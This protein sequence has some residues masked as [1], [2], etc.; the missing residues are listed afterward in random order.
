[1]TPFQSELI[2][3]KLFSKTPKITFFTIASLY[4]DF[5][6]L[7]KI[8]IYS[9]KFRK[10]A[11]SAKQDFHNFI[12]NYVRALFINWLG[13]KE[14]LLPEWTGVLSSLDCS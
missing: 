8:R 1:M 6:M 10:I 5:K 14:I 11:S 12:L 4:K 3:T 2:V 9:M 13:A 7:R